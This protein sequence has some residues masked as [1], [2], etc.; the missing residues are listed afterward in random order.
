ML[1]SRRIDSTTALHCVVGSLN[2]QDHDMGLLWTRAL[3]KTWSHGTRTPCVNN[4]Q[5]RARSH[6]H[7]QAQGH[8]QSACAPHTD[9]TCGLR[10]FGRQAGSTP[11]PQSRLTAPNSEPRMPPLA[12]LSMRALNATTVRFK[13]AG[14]QTPSTRPSAPRRRPLRADRRH[15]APSHPSGSPCGAV[16]RPAE[17]DAE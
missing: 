15:A 4:R 7:Q 17:G 10:R 5:Q 2:A 16:D 11:G 12:M 3:R 14:A 1:N 8:S 9:H 6:A 13:A